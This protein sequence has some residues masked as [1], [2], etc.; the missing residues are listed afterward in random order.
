MHGLDMKIFVGIIFLFLFFG[1]SRQDVESSELEVGSRPNYTSIDLNVTY[2]SYGN[3]KETHGVFMKGYYKFVNS[4]VNL[5]LPDALPDGLFVIPI[6]ETLVSHFGTCVWAY[7]R[8]LIFVTILMVQVV[9]LIIS[10]SRII[11]SCLCSNSKCS[12]ISSSRSKSSSNKWMWL[13]WVYGTLS[14]LLLM[15]VMANQSN[16]HMNQG[17]D[18]VVLTLDDTMDD[19]ATYAETTVNQLQILLVTNLQDYLNFFIISGTK[20]TANI[21]VDL[22]KAIQALDFSKMI[23]DIIDSFKIIKPIFEEIESILTEVENL[24]KTINKEITH[25]KNIVEKMICNNKDCEKLKSLVTSLELVYDGGV[26]LANETLTGLEDMANLGKKTVNEGIN[27]VG[28]I[29]SSIGGEVIKEGKDLGKITAGI[30]GNVVKDLEKTGKDIKNLTGTIVNDVAGGLVKDIKNGGKAVEDVAGKVATGIDKVAGGVGD[31]VEDTI[32]DVGDMALGSGDKKKK[33]K[34]IIGNVVN[35]IDSGIDDVFSSGKKKKPAK[36]ATTTVQPVKKKEEVLTVTIPEVV[37]NAKNTSTSI[38]ETFGLPEKK[39]KIKESTMDL[40][41]EVPA[42]KK[43]EN[44]VESTIDLRFGDPSSK[45]KDKIEESTMDLTSFLSDSKNNKVNGAVTPKKLDATAKTTTNIAT[46]T[47]GILGGF[48][49]NK[50]TLRLAP[51][52]PK[53]KKKKKE[54]GLLDTIASGVSRG[55]DKV[56]HLANEVSGGI[57]DAAN[58]L[59][60]GF[61]KKRNSEIKSRKLENVANRVSEITGEGSLQD[62]TFRNKRGIDFNL[63]LKEEFDMIFTT[64]DT[65]EKYITSDLKK[66]N[67]VNVL[68]S[69]LFKEIEN[70]IKEVLVEVEKELKEAAEPIEKLFNSTLDKIVTVETSIL[71]ATNVLR[72]AQSVISAFEVFR[73]HASNFVTTALLISFCFLLLG[74]CMRMV[75]N[76]DF[77]RCT[78]KWGFIFLHVTAL[79][80]AVTSVVYIGAGV[81]SQKILCDTLDTNHRENNIMKILSSINPAKFGLFLDFNVHKVIIRC[82]QDQSLY[83]V[84]NLKS[85]LNIEKIAVE[86]F[87]QKSIEKEFD[88]LLGLQLNFSKFLPLDI[89]HTF[90]KELSFEAFDKMLNLPIFAQIDTLEKEFIDIPVVGDVIKTIGSSID[91]YKDKITKLKAPVKSA[92]EGF[93]SFLSSLDKMLKGIENMILEIGRV[94]IG[95]VERVVLQFKNILV[96]SLM[97]Y[98]NNRLIYS[99]Q[100]KVGK[101]KPISAAFNSTLNSVCS[102]ITTPANGHWFSLDVAVLVAILLILTS[103]IVFN[104]LSGGLKNDENEEQIELK[105][106]GMQD[107]ADK[108]EKQTTA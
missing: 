67:N 91:I 22:G 52:T 44:L 41:F 66:L 81:T 32:N 37:D 7:R 104:Q 69:P 19:I 71:N 70:V 38:I 93:P 105:C 54:K 74:V 73:Y 72:D 55:V 42:P 39:D 1:F 49:L 5:I 8:L 31:E 102:K 99:I 12:K 35:E 108:V 58:D 89:I 45:K 61:R 36:I 18:T 51:T 15:L 21:I 94:A 80:M 64:I 46:T 28:N 9:F 86:F 84:T 10:S 27:V 76:N 98:V 17:I 4:F 14:L 50:I 106:I 87:D 62:P 100:H 59:I 40:T 56:D 103:R 95:T 107:A 26:E 57:D 90:D 16:Q 25:L 53:P 78:Y 63:G 85:I 88:S 60:G 20:A 43:K 92:K 13:S 82:H 48:G 23:D 3:H 75:F 33:S 47:E 65:I 96:N 68:F 11:C 6:G 24:G 83:E 29:T 30:A 77:T 2:K 101:C 97:D 79:L 34:S